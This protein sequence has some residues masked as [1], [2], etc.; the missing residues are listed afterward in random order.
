[1]GFAQGCRIGRNVQDVILNLEGQA[2]GGGILLQRGQLIGGQLVMTQGAQSDGTFD[3]GTG[4][5]TMDLFE[6]RQW[7][8]LPFGRQIQRLSA[9]H[10]GIT[11][12]ARQLADHQ[13][14]VG[15]Q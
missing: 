1:M 14:L 7:H 9:T 12:G 3:Q 15:A 6:R 2:D 4:L 10:A 13:Q 8:L 11:G 5:V